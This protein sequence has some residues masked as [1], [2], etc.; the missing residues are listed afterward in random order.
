M[1]FDFGDTLL[2][3][4]GKIAE[5]NK[6]SPESDGW[7]RSGWIGR[8]KAVGRIALALA[9]AAGVAYIEGD[10]QAHLKADPRAVEKAAVKAFEVMGI[11][12]ISPSGSALDSEA[13]GQTADDTKVTVK[14]KIEA[15]GESSVPIRIGTF[16]DEA[17]SRR[18]LDEINKQ[19]SAAR[20]YGA[21]TPSLG[22]MPTCSML[23]AQAVGTKCPA[24][25]R[26]PSPV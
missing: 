12:R 17:M 6:V 23:A 5:L 3:A 4:A 20:R 21:D 18:I 25:H 1:D 10:L 9:V 8:F 7:V 22:R 16:G 15:S 26:C 2:I 24:G 11:T 19:Y 13:I 14:A